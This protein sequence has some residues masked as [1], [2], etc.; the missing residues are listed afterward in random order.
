MRQRVTSAP[1]KMMFYT[2]S[3]RKDPSLA[4]NRFKRFGGGGVSDV[5]SDYG[6]TRNNQDSSRDRAADDDHPHIV[7]IG[8]EDKEASPADFVDEIGDAILEANESMWQLIFH[9]DAVTK[10][11]FPVEGNGEVES[12]GDDDS[13]EDGG[14]IPL[15]MRAWNR[16]SSMV[17][18]GR[19]KAQE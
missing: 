17:F 19:T 18:M 12:H 9:N 3:A 2:T 14:G 11:I 1:S 10:V 6:T 7:T 13:L 8:T 15:F 16:V 5:R 4:R